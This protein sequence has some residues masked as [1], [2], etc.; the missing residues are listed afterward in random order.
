[1]L[2]EAQIPIPPQLQALFQVPTCSTIALPEAGSP[3]QLRLP[4]GASFTAIADLSK[5]IPTDCSMATSLIVQLAPFL[6]SIECLLKVL[7]LIEPLVKFVKA[8]PSLAPLDIAEAGAEIIEA[9]AKLAPCIGMIMPAT[10]A[11]LFFIKDLL[12]IIIR[13]IKCM[14]GSLETILGIMQGIE[15]RLEAANTAGNAELAELLECARENATTAA[16]HA[17]SSLGPVQNIMPLI[18]SFLELAN[19]SFELPELGSPEDSAALAQ[20]IQ[21]LNDTITTL[22]T[23]VET[24]P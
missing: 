1:M 2:H 16:A 8:V 10:P 9:A 13:M 21:T 17:Q 11:I 22:E 19:I 20:T 14:I 18:M 6:A 12:L 24:L 3:M 5:G 4:N 23:V 15:L 7:A